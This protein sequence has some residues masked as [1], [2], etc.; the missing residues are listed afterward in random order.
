[1]KMGDKN[2]DL[3]VGVGSCFVFFVVV[4]LRG[5]GSNILVHIT[6]PPT[7]SSTATA[8]PL[9]LLLLQSPQ[10]KALPT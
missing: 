7:I 10:L 9:Q 5:I 8:L 2:V 1:M 4:V 3:G 6:I